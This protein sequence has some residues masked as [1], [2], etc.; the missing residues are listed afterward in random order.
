MVNTMDYDYKKNL[1]IFFESK[2]LIERVKE[3]MVYKLRGSMDVNDLV[4]LS[5]ESLLDIYI[6]HN[7]SREYI[8]FINNL[9]TWASQPES[10]KNSM[11]WSDLHDDWQRILS[12]KKDLTM[13]Y[14]SIW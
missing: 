7:N 11:F 8:G 14:K 12:L 4:T 6:P 1:R 9:C 2:Q 3:L 5:F 10:K 13:A